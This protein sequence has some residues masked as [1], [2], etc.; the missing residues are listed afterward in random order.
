MEKNMKNVL[1]VFSDP[2]ELEFIEFHLSENGFKVFTA[3]N[4]E[5]AL[6]KAEEIVPD[7]IVINTLNTQKEV[8]QFSKLLK[9]ERLNNVLLLC[10]IELEDYLNASSKKHLVIKPVRP[11]LLLS[12]I[13]GIMNH[14]EINWL[15]AVH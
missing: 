5:N 13:R 2:Q 10:L 14:E 1:L 3:A 11:K 6:K 9:T 8:D 12:L 4:L 15:L 7:L